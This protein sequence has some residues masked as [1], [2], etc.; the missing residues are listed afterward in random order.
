M[1]ASNVRSK[2]EVFPF[3]QMCGSIFEGINAVLSA[4]CATKPLSTAVGQRSVYNGCTVSFVYR[5]FKINIR[6]FWGYS[7]RC[8]L[9]YSF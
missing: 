2:S 1:M 6:S 9:E 8:D 4:F 3:N 5:I 7:I